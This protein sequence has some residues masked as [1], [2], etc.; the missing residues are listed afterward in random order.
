MIVLLQCWADSVC[1]G[2]SNTVAV[3][4]GVDFPKKKLAHCDLVEPWGDQDD[5][6]RIFHTSTG[7]I[8]GSETGEASVCA[9]CHLPD[10][11]SRHRD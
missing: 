10:P 2:R 5:V 8:H 4:G 6:P 9:A 11:I 1:S 7:A 3:N